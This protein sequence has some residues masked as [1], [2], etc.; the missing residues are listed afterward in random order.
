LRYPEGFPEPFFIGPVSEWNWEVVTQISP[1]PESVATD[2]FRQVGSFSTAV[3]GGS[4]SSVP[5]STSIVI[6]SSEHVSDK[7][8]STYLNELNPW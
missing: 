2:H 6:S 4:G 7:T 1:L 8:L 5:K 3:G